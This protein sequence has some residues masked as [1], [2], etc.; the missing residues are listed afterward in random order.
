MGTEDRRRRE[1]ERRRAAILRAA[2]HDFAARGLDGASMGAIA[3][4]AELG[5]ATLYYYFETKEELH[6]AVLAEGTERFFASLGAMDARFDSLPDLVEGVLRAYVGYFADHPALLRVTAP[7]LSHIHWAHQGS[8]DPGA[9]PPTGGAELSAHLSFLSELQ[10]LLARSPWA[11]RETAFL[12][13]LADVFVALSQR[14]TAGL[15]EG[16][17][18]QVGFY[19]DL[20]RGY[21]KD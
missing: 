2:T 13:F 14:V 3:R 8:P 18:E 15:D 21:R 5:K 9:H 6:A 7:Y 11:G 16:V 20:V 10:R 12:G 17:E 19:V 1:R 4:G